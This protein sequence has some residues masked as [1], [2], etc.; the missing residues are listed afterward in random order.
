MTNEMH[1]IAFTRFL[2]SSFVIR[3]F[4]ISKFEFRRRNLIKSLAQ[5][6]PQPVGPGD[7]MRISVALGKRVEPVE[8]KA[9]CNRVL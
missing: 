4:V 7:L 6:T 3:T 5:L 2:H 9:S 1:S 8:R